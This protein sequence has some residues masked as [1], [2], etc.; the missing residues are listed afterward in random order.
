MSAAAALAVGTVIDHL[1]RRGAALH[2]APSIPGRSNKPWARARRSQSARSRNSIRPP[3]PRLLVRP[4]GPVAA[5]LSRR[6]RRPPRSAVGA[7]CRRYICRRYII[8]SPECH[9]VNVL[10]FEVRPTLEAFNQEQSL[11]AVHHCSLSGLQLI[12]LVLER[13]RFPCRIVHQRRDFDHVTVRYLRLMRSRARTVPA[14]GSTA[15]PATT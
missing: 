8:R 14:C 15:A 1:D 10:V 6:R 13:L 12:G 7:Y 11:A 9:S 2:T 4:V 5:S 3:I